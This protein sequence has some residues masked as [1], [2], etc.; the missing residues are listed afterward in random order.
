MC[1]VYILSYL[2]LPSINFILFCK[3]LKNHK[4]TKYDPKLRVTSDKS[5]IMEHLQDY[6]LKHKELSDRLGVAEHIKERNTTILRG[7]LGKL[8]DSIENKDNI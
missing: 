6:E 2:N 3:E 5:N 8:V 4:D 1:K 7:E